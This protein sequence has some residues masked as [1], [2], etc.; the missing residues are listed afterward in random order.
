MRRGGW[1]QRL[2]PFDCKLVVVLAVIVLLSFLLLLRR[3]VGT[4]VLV[5][6]G[7]RTLFVADLSVDR[8]VELNGPLG[9]TVL[10][11]AD[12]GVRILS[13]PCSRKICIGMGEARHPGDLLACVPNRLV[14]RIEGADAVA[15]ERGYDFLSR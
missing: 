11:I 5:T 9:T 10:Q 8:R 2:T 4:R 14:V 15:R 3:G 13:S 12:G 7:D 1:L 6:S